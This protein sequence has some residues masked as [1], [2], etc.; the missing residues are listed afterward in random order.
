MTNAAAMHT[1]RVAIET[2]REPHRP[3]WCR[4]PNGLVGFWWGDADFG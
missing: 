3:T 4:Q 2:V 1:I